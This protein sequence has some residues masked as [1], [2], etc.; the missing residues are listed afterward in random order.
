MGPM[1]NG[2][3]RGANLTSSGEEKTGGKSDV[4]R[5]GEVSEKR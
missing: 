4:Q 2:G 5:D 1:E 3:P